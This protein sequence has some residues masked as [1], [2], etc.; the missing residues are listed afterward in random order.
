MRMHPLSLALA[1]C[2]LLAL[3]G[4]EAG[5]LW[6]DGKDADP[7]LLNPAVCRTSQAGPPAMLRQFMLAQAKT[8][9]RPFNPTL[10]PQPARPPAVTT[11]PLWPD[12]GTLSMP[13]TTRSPEA[14]RYF[15]QGLRLSFAFNHG[16]AQRAFRAAQALDPDCAMCYWG[17]ALVLGPNINAPMFPEALAP[18]RAAVKRAQSLTGRAGP[19]EQA[20]IAAIA[21]RYGED[22]KADR[23][24]FDIAYAEAMAEAARRFPEDDNVQ[25]LYAEALMD[26]QPWDYWEAG[27]ARPKGR[28]GELVPTLEKVLQRNPEHPGAI[29]LYIH[30]VE[31]SDNPKR[32]LPHARRLGELMPA[33]GHMVHMPSHI[34]YR[35]GLYQDALIT[36]QKAVAADER[37][38]ART[39]PDPFYRNAYYP[40]NL[41]FLMVSAQMGGD[42][43][44]ALE[45]ANKLDQAIDRD[46]LKAAPA[47]QPVKAA[48]YFTH[49]QFSD[50]ATILALPDPGPD[51][52]LVQA[53]WRYARAVALAEE[54]DAAGAEKEIAALR[55]IEAHGDFKPL[56]DWQVPGQAIVQTARLVASGRLAAAR[57]ELAG[58]AKAYEEAAAIQDSL[59]YMEP[60]YWYYPVRQSLGAVLLRAGQFDAAEQAFRA[61]LVKTPQN[62]WALYGLRQLY[63]QR[64]D[65]KAAKAAEKALQGAWFGDS[66]RLDLARL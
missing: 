27:G 43:K 25:T 41:H 56:A 14:Q 50:P 16:E 5:A 62:G 36:N 33:A 60:P 8:E 66:S 32:A 26:L 10:T 35:V 45:A 9:T 53:M 64:G 29:H 42:G 57:G 19:R 55:D 59:S 54:K 52:I 21:K 48:P 23:A 12:L 37:H 3:P 49:A 11:P 4:S 40:H 63:L 18:A 2:G 28:V 61:S 38:F 31:A 17:E 46:F 47:L 15:D 65:A 1:V 51:F 6:A 13:I 34:Y 30:A 7:L 20:L 39:S 22:P 44:V 24:P 58:A